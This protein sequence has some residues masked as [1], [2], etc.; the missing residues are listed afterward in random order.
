MTVSECRST[1]EQ[2]T[3]PFRTGFR[4]GRNER[5]EVLALLGVGATAVVLLVHDHVGGRRAAAKFLRS[6]EGEHPNDA[7]FRARAEA[8]TLK[9]LRHENIVKVHEVGLCH[10]TA[11]VL[12]EHRDGIA[13]D[14]LVEK[15]PLPIPCALDIAVQLAGAL[16]HA[17]AAGVLHLDV[18]PG[19]VWVAREGGVKLLDFGMD[20]DFERAQREAA[21][22][23]RLLFG[24][25]AY[26]APEQWRL[27][28]P[29]ARTDVWSL[30][31]TLYELVTGELPFAKS[32]EHPI[33]ICEAVVSNGAPPPISRRL[34]A[35]PALDELL[36]R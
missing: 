15:G 28:T 25:P 6:Y 9:K 26:M 13:L 5:Y 16:A 14:K 24:T 12:L 21:T 8:C 1:E 31:M 36:R 17:H 23:P 33:L 27:M 30:G 4:F 35:P 11:Y 29:D 3:S 20:A 7:L 2:P 19:N 22:R 18:K 32:G 10:E 34:N